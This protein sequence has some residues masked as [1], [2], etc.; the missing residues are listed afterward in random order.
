MK[1]ATSGVLVACLLSSAGA[2]PIAAQNGDPA[3]ARLAAGDTA[4]AIDLFERLVRDHRNDASL[5]FELGTLYSTR[6]AA[7][8]AK[9][10]SAA[11]EH[12]RLATRL[13]PD[14]AGYWLALARVLR[15]ATGVGSR[16]QVTGSLERA[17]QAASR[18]GSPL[19]AEIRYRLGR[20]GWER[21]EQ[22]ADRHDLVNGLAE[23]DQQ[24]FLHDWDYVLNLFQ[25]HLR[26]SRSGLPEWKETR[27]YLDGALA[28]DSLH[29]A[30]AGLHVVALGEMFR[31]DSAAGFTGRLVAMAPDS[32]WSWA[33]HGLTLARTGQWGEAET[34]FD[35]ALLRLS[36]ADG[37]PYLALERVL[38]PDV[39]RRLAE[40]GP[41]ERARF[42]TAHWRSDDPLWIT[43]AN[44]AHVEFLAR[45]TYADHRWADDLRGY[46]GY[47]S[48]R[49]A[50]YLR[51]GPPDKAA[52]VGPSG[53][54]VADP[55]VSGAPRR[56]PGDALRR[57]A[58]LRLD[59]ERNRVL[60]V[61]DLSQ[62]RY[63][64]GLVTGYA[65]AAFAGDAAGRFEVDR[66]IMPRRWDNIPLVRTMDSV[67]VRALRFAGEPGGV[68]L[69]VFA[70]VRP[71]LAQF[72]DLDANSSLALF[73]EGAESVARLDADAA[74]RLRRTWR[75][76]VPW[77]ADSMPRLRVEALVPRRV[78]AARGI[79][80]PAAWGAAADQHFLSDIL[81]AS[82]SL[83]PG[84]FN[85]WFELAATPLTGR[86]AA[87]RPLTLAWEIY[88][89]GTETD[90][91]Y[92]V[93]VR[94]TAEALR[95][96]G[97]VARIVGG[98]S[99]ALGL[100]A[101]G[102]DAIVLR[103]QRSRPAAPALLE[104]LTLDLGDTPAG[105]YRITIGVTPDGAVR[106]A[107]SETVIEIDVSR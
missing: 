61:Y 9:A 36:P 37:A 59:N 16:R 18:H 34:A 81:A 28:V 57:D 43:S 90:A 62:R 39:N 103:Y 23:I 73:V 60:W 4:G 7:D 50:V 95:R 56:D 29:R 21:Y 63:L 82:D 10:R 32:G 83:P 78:R 67:T 55:S 94:L 72:M 53:A 97:L 31:W 88:G 70:S 6:I 85:R 42:T 13:A 48:D 74:L 14:S 38:A 12:L 51:Y 2:V 30:A 106:P 86:L 35:S 102:D 22:V 64:F 93:E 101:V 54:N 27:K 107:V 105:R 76:R 79:T 77:A 44:E 41:D 40:F 33:L 104:Y 17:E 80:T 96:Q 98:A 65:R 5:H 69:A 24:L 71:S 19:L 8:D 47:E 52:T 89:I 20:A 58:A 66:Q 91:T 11:E 1:A 99:D 68:E 45:V 26:R 75:W 100:S 92:A 25:H 84:T 15:M 46:R 3:R 49:G 87:G